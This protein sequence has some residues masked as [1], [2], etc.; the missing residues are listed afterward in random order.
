MA[1][2]SADCKQAIVDHIATHPGCVDSQFVETVDETPAKNMRN[3][4]RYNKEKRP[5][6]FTER[7]FECRSYG[8]GDELRAYTID[9][10]TLILDVL[11]QGE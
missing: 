6:G 5:N 4:R 9:D 2:R 11:I 8:D 10:G 1:I 7:G 3:W